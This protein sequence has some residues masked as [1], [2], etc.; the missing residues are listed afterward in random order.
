MGEFPL[1]RREQ[2]SRIINQV[3]DRQNADPAFGPRF[4]ISA[5]RWWDRPRTAWR[6]VHLLT[7]Q[8]RP[9]QTERQGRIRSSSCPSSAPPGGKLGTQKQ[10]SIFCARRDG[11]LSANVRS[12]YFRKWHWPTVRCGA[13]FRQLL[14]HS[15]SDW[16]SSVSSLGV[17][18]R[19]KQISS[20]T[21]LNQTSLTGRPKHQR[22]SRA[23]EQF[24][25]VVPHSLPQPHMVNG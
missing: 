2:S 14:G 3:G 13:P 21:S 22:P 24:S 15:V 20:E 1:C 12:I 6:R 7:R 17:R 10:S 9:E 18:L 8:R 11:L 4:E 16:R 25:C 19:V 5:R 23:A